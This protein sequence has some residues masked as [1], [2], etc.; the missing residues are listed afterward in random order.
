M[1]ILIDELPKSLEIEGIDYPIN[2]DYESCLNIIMAFEDEDLLYDEKIFSIMLSCLYK[3]IPTNLQ[4]AIDNAF[5]FLNGGETQSENENNYDIPVRLYSFTK[6]ANYIYA[7]FRQTHGI[8]L[9]SVKMHWWEFIA[10]FMDL[11]SETSF[12]NLVNLR[13]RIKDGTATKEEKDMAMK[14]G[15]IFDLPEYDRRTYEEKME[16]YEKEIIWE[17]NSRKVIS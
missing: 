10:L 17:E 3:K 15:D 12:T 13:K 2:Y 14:M 9:R 1:N 8:N 16:D 11:G 4:L 6:D 5:W 7:A